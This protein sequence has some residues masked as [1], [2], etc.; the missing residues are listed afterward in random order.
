MKT[1]SIL[2]AGL[3][4]T[5]VGLIGAGCS[6]G[7][8]DTRV[9]GNLNRVNPSKQVIT[10]WHQHPGARGEAMQALI[11]DFNATNKWGITVRGEF[12]GSYA[13]I[14][15]RIMQG[16]PT[17]DLPDISVAYQNQ[18]G[19]YATHKAVVELTPYIES[20]LWGFTAA[21]LADFF[22]FVKL[23][24]HL[25]QFNGQYGFPPQR[26]MEVLYYNEDWLHELGYDAP[27]RTWDE[28]AR[29]ACA[30]SDPNAKTFGYELAIDASTFA[31]MVFNR[32]GSMIDEK[33]KAYTF[34]DQAGLDAVTGVQELFK[35]GCAVL[36]KEPEGDQ[37]D[38]GKRRVL[39][40]VTSTSSLT[41]VR[42]AVGGAF[43]WSVS[44][45]PTTLDSARVNIYGASLSIMRSRPEKQLAAWLFIKWLTA[46]E[47]SARWTRASDYFPVRQSAKDNLADYFAANPQFAKAF[48][49]LGHQIAIEPGVVGYDECRDRIGGMLSAVVAGEDP[50][51][52]L[53]A[54]V[55]ECNGFLN[56]AVSK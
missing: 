38:F 33:A 37:S 50:A 49:F 9:Y 8:Y 55:K 34:G 46:P 22:P 29:M 48:G 56:P 5:F 42:D 30:A 26:S 23:G 31:D 11:Q 20:P 35:R 24:D 44:T 36:E 19:T 47:Q 14:Y 3:L 12:A 27:P 2:A 54:T 18:A 32:G 21:E 13:E 15:Q 6:A 51:G 17:H 28:F 39:F 4:L 52:R 41:F 25:P 40:I 45:M 10:F 1:Y 53:A 16:I 7:P 43:K